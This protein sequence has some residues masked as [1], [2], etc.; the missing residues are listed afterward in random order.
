MDLNNCFADMS[1]L[2]SPWMVGEW[3]SVV[4]MH[5]DGWGNTI[6]PPTESLGLRVEVTGS[7]LMQSEVDDRPNAPCMVH[8]QVRAYG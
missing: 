2:P 1:S 3:A 6:Y 8:L 4:I 5:R 7:G